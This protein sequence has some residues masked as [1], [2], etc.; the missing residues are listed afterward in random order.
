MSDI[1]QK[2]L[3]DL[4]DRKRS[5]MVELAKTDKAIESLSALLN[6]DEKIKIFGKVRH[7]TCQFVDDD[8]KICGNAY[9]AKKENKIFCDEK[10][11]KSKRKLVSQRNVAERKAKEVRAKDKGTI[12]IPGAT[13]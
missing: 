11:C 7:G 3:N 6:R 9:T 13:K 8:G 5:L 1:I 4:K 12:L 10:D 2:S